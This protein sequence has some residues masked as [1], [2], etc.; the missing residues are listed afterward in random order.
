M[1]SAFF[2]LLKV[3]FRLPPS[4]ASPPPLPPCLKHV[5]AS[6][7][8]AS[9]S[10]ALSVL[11]Q[12]PPSAYGSFHHPKYHPQC[13]APNTSRS[14]SP[15]SASTSSALLHTLPGCAWVFRHHHHHP[16]MLRFKCERVYLPSLGFYLPSLGFYLPYCHRLHDRRLGLTGRG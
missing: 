7:H 4:A 13:L 5:E 12:T 1:V 10:P 16:L 6:P 2:T 9:T 15:Q 8:L 14:T 11:L 3:Y